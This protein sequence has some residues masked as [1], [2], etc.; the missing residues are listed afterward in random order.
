MREI[1]VIRASEGECRPYGKFTRLMDNEC[2]TGDGWECWMTEELCM[3]HGAKVSICHSDSVQPYVL[4]AMKRCENSQTLVICGCESMIIALTEDGGY[5]KPVSEK[6]RAYGMEPGEIL[7]LNPGVWHDIC[8][9]TDKPIDYYTLSLDEN[10][11]ET[12]TELEGEAV[13]VVLKEV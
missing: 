10:P 2:F 7:L 6:V 11:A 13:R 5:G 4:S 9:G 12:F 3:D 1:E 8:R